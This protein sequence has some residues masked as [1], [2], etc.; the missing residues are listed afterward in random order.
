MVDSSSASIETVISEHGQA[1]LP[2]LIKLLQDAVASGASVGFP[3][4]L[5]EEEASRYWIQF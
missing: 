4:P 3:P 2:K 5:S 1:L